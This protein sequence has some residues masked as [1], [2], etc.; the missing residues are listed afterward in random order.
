MVAVPE[1]WSPVPN[2]IPGG[3]PPLPVPHGQLGPSHGIRLHNP[4]R[5]PPKKPPGQRRDNCANHPSLVRFHSP[6]K[7]FC[8]L[9]FG[10][11][12]M[13]APPLM[14]RAPSVRWRLVL[15]ALVTGEG[16]GVSSNAYLSRS[17]RLYRGFHEILRDSNKDLQKFLS[18]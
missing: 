15:G 8:R 12:E 2:P 5:P 16:T 1:G 11:F 13:S 18:D 9:I 4:I 3:F 7:P 17:S 10:R 6:W 14:R